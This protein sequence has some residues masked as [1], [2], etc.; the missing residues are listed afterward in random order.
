MFGV[1]YTPNM[2]IGL[3]LSALLLGRLV[4]RFLVVGQA[5]N[6]APQPGANPFATYTQNPLTLA[7]FTLLFGYYMTYFVGV[8]I[9][10]R[11]PSVT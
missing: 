2:Y 3:A 9:R 11:K 7:L 5:M 10:A 4:Y 8:L 1:F 6:T